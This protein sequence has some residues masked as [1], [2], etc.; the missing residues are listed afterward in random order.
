MIVGL[1][2]IM[3]AL[4]ANLF[5]DE[6]ISRRHWVGLFVGVLGLVLV[7]APKFGIGDTGITLANILTYIVAMFGA[8]FG[9]IY[10]KKFATGVQLRT[11]TF[12]QYAGALIPSLLLAL[13]VEDFA[14]DWNAELIFAL[15]W[16]VLVLSI[17]AIFLLMMLIRNGSVAKVSS[18]LFLVPATTAIM[19]FFLFGETLSLLQLSG[20][21]L[22]AAAV[23]LALKPGN[24]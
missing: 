8:T 3:V 7:L 15:I 21:V 14:F 19:A 10:Q 5:L 20:M 24:H 23:R 17:G 4:L 2:P 12:W 22:C 6:P 18:L 11:G 13:F 1:Q 16:A 9:T